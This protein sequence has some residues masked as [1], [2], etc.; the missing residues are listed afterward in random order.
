[1]AV[2]AS[3]VAK[4]ERELTEVAPVVARIG[5]LVAGTTGRITVS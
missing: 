5:H 2:P 3:S 4:V 1:M